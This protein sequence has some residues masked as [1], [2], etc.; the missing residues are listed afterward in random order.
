MEDAGILSVY[1]KLQ[2]VVKSIR[3]F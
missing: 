2:I 3:N 1:I